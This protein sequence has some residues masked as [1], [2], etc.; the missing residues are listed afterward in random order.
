MYRSAM[1]L[2]FVALGLAAAGC[3]DETTET[4]SVP[5]AEAEGVPAGGGDLELGGDVGDTT[6]TSGNSPAG[7]R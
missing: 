3:G 7:V 2:A 5:G 4:A 6:G 1:V